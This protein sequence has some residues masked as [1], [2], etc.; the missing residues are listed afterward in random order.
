MPLVLAMTEELSPRMIGM[1]E[2]L[3]TDW[4]YLDERI[5]TVSDE[6]ATLSEQDEGA[7][8]LM[9]VP[10]IGPI[11]S[12]QQLPRLAGPMCSPRAE[13]SA[14]GSVWCRDR[15]RPAARTVLGSI[16]KRSNRYLRML[17][18]QGP[19]PFC[20]IRR[21]G[22]SMASTTGSR[23]RPGG[24]I[25]S[26]WQLQSPTSSLASLGAFCM[27]GATSKSDQ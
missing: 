8:R 15:C 12:L 13:I 25:G 18:V 5:K 14:H 17:F 19:T 9:T 11:I 22:K 1:I 2:D 23:P 16:S 24:S 27:A 6:I 10:G 20:C 4:R 3:C 21:V 7:K 26:S